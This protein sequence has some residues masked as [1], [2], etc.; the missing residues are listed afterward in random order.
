MARR[1]RRLPKPLGS[2]RLYLGSW[3]LPSGNSCNVYLG[4]T[5]DVYFEWDEPP[6]PAWPPAD[7]QHY[8]AVLFPAV[9]TAVAMELGHRRVLGVQL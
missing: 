5:E 7:V 4:P 9:L 6:S 1:R 8:H 3:V 2:R